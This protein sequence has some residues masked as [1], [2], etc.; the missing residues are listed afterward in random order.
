M[1]QEV[2]ERLKEVNGNGVGVTTILTANTKQ[3]P[4]ECGL[5][6]QRI[7]NQVDVACIGLNAVSKG[8]TV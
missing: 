5:W 1:F 7:T 4:R 3:G 2:R 8:S 6:L